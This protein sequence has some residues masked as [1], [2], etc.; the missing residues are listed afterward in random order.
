MIPLEMPKKEILLRSQRSCLAGGQ[1]NKKSLQGNSQVSFQARN[2]SKGIPR[3]PSKLT[4]SPWE[5]ET[6]FQGTGAFSPLKMES[7][8]IIP[9]SFS[10]KTGHLLIINKTN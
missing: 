4:G 2:H 8:P 1:S 3:C 6:H 5:F 9:S 7:L 10:M